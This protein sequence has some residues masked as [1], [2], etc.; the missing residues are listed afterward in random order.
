MSDRDQ[1]DQPN[2]YLVTPTR[3][4]IEAFAPRLAAILDAEPI[5]CLR[6]AL[7]DRGRG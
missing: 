5:A 7:A 1:T 2:L 4:E 3:F 6:L